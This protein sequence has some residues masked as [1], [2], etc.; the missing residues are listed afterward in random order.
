MTMTKADR[1]EKS[2]RKLVQFGES[3]RPI[4]CCHRIFSLFV[5]VA[6]CG[7]GLPP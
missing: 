3:G 2:L 7:V 4:W 6:D 5:A 1:E